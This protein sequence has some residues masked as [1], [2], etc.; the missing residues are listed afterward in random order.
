[1]QKYLIVVFPGLEFRSCSFCH[2]A[3]CFYAASSWIIACY[4]KL[5]CEGHVA[6]PD[7]M[8]WYEPV[9]VVYMPQVVICATWRW[10]A[11]DQAWNVLLNV[12]VPQE[13]IVR[14]DAHF[15]AYITRNVEVVG[16]KEG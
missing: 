7:F 3:V 4:Y 10:R 11:Y 1:M 16:R 9:G 6:E 2:Q 8:L 13:I 14:M 12:T 5:S 15:V